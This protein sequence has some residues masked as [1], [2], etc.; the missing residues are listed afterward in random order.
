[1]PLVVLFLHI[2]N[3]TT[4]SKQKEHSFERCL[5]GMSRRQAV[6]TQIKNAISALI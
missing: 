3:E 1:M 5:T 2:K 4:I 6:G